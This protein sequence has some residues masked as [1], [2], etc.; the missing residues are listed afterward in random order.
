MVERHLWTA[1]LVQ[2][3]RDLNGNDT[4]KQRYDR[5]QLRDDTRLWFE[6]DNIETGSF[7]WIC[8]QLEIDALQLQRRVLETVGERAMEPRLASLSI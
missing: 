4:P 1:V 3:I 2:A 7:R 8:D 5:S 6:S